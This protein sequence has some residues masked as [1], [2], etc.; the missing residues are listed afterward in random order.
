V[1]PPVVRTLFFH[2]KALAIRV[3]DVADRDVELRRAA[4]RGVVVERDVA[5]KSVP[6]TCESDCQLLG[7]I[8]RPIGANDE[9][10]IEVADAD[11]ASLRARGACE[12]EED[13]EE[14]PTNR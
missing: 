12:R 11:G 4:L 9:Q 2:L 8:E 6:L 3:G 10:R 13:E 1:R 7:N 14:C 5:V